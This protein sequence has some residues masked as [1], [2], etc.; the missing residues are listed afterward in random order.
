MGGAARII[1]ALE[2]GYTSPS[3]FAGDYP[4]NRLRRRERGDDLLEVRIAERLPEG[5]QV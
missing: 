3:H 5:M 1:V 2:L 4:A